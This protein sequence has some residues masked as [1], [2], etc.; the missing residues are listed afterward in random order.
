MNITSYFRGMNDEEEE[1]S[2]RKT[3]FVRLQLVEHAPRGT[4]LIHS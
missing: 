1:E 3:L 2:E 4:W